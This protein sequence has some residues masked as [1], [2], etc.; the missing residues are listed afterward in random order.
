MKR[1]HLIRLPALLLSLLLLLPAC[2]R[3]TPP[4]PPPADTDPTE[5]KEEPEMI[6]YVRLTEKGQSLYDAT[7]QTMLDRTHG[8]GYAQT[9]LTGAYSGMFVRDASIQVMAHVAN[10]DYDYAASLL[11]YMIGF[12]RGM[13]KDFAVHIMDEPKKKELYSTLSVIE[14]PDESTYF[15]ESS[16]I[17]LYKITLPTNAAAQ[18]FSVPF[19][20]FSEVSFYLQNSASEG[21]LFVKIGT[22]PD[23]DSIASAEADLN[24]MKSGFVTV[25][26]ETPVSVEPGETY[27]MTIAAQDADG[28]VV[29]SG[30]TGGGKVISYNY[31][32]PAYGGWAKT[33]NTLA[34]RIGKAPSKDTLSPDGTVK[35]DENE[36]VFPADK[37]AAFLTSADLVLSGAKAKITLKYGDRVVGTVEKE[38]TGKPETVT[39]D[40][41]LPT[42]TKDE[43]GPWSITVEGAELYGTNGTPAALVTFSKL[44]AISEKVQVDGNY[45]FV[46]AFA[47]FALLDLPEYRDMVKE[48]Y[49]LFSDF[50]WYFLE[51]ENYHH[52]N[53]LL[54]NPNY[55]HSR[56]GRYWDCYDPITNCFASEAL[57]K[58]SAVAALLGYESDRNAFASEADAIAAAVHETLVSDFNGKTIYTE[59][60]ALDE[61]GKEYKGFS[62]VNLAP[63]ACD[64][65]AMDEE[66]MANTY[67][68]YLTAC[69]KYD[70]HDMLPVTV[71][72]NENDEI[73]GKGNHVIGKGLAW[74][75]HY[76]WVT[77]N[78]ERLN[79][80]LTFIDGRSRDT[81]PETWLNTGKMADSANQEQ[82]S[83]M[84]YEI[85]R[86][87]GKSKNH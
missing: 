70:G 45:M 47:M 60:I 75:I 12:H 7:Y 64:W 58:M 61:K 80:M 38:L 6:N 57:H 62:F 56:D 72:L 66:I 17:A 15:Q 51:D 29:L 23:D 33:G 11:S 9:S 22:A 14:E 26:F 79:E 68:A 43:K 86:I 59:M 8:N 4:S 25:P 28:N 32:K 44:N 74:E 41:P 84:L 82:A 34:F 48:S 71:V 50:A 30:I 81:Y 76:L 24:G 78:T 54:R 42:F 65:Y 52:E 49:D 39:V 36:I 69:E 21:T 63:I 5:T 85:A 55:E 3:E 16:A 77:G 83:W 1:K 19:S 40:F 67:E 73:T 2:T 10:G 31:D 53:G 87:T 37:N 13:K 27:V 20:S 46:N 18:T 35:T